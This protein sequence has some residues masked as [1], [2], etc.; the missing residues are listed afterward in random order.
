[1]KSK[2]PRTKG[3]A[4]G[5]V[6]RGRASPRTNRQWL[7]I[8]TLDDLFKH[9]RAIVERI[10]QTHN[11]G[12]LFLTNPLMLLADIGV[13]LSTR[14]K[15][16]LIRNEPRIGAHSESAYRALKETESPQSVTIR[17]KGLFERK[18]DQ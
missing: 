16:E 11:G 3:R 1:M 8:Q 17:L 15:S 10:N 6:V 13:S 9:E 14:A 4:K 7:S 12:Y 18:S 2:R 5:A